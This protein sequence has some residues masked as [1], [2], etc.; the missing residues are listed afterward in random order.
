[1]LCSKLHIINT[2]AN[3]GS[4]CGIVPSMLDSD[5]LVSEF[6]LRSGYYISLSENCSCKRY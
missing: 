3:R 2:H 1:M 4:G 5:I 6:E